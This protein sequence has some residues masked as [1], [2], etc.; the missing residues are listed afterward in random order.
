MRDKLRIY[1]LACT[2]LVHI[3]SV[4]GELQILSV[5]KGL[6]ASM[7]HQLIM[8]PCRRSSE[9]MVS[10]FGRQSGRQSTMHTSRAA[11]RTRSSTSLGPRRSCFYFLPE[12]GA[13][14]SNFPS[15]SS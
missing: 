13:L 10:G 4:E 7:L 1:L 14:S 5:Q 6:L 8:A 15:T 11:R 12:M 3:G 2:L 9:L